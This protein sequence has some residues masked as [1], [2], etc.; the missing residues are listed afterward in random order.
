MAFPLGL[1][2]PCFTALVPAPTKHFFDARGDHAKSVCVDA[3]MAAGF[4]AE[5][6]FAKTNNT[7][8]GVT[9]IDFKV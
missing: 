6:G 9:R 4:T 1:T 3:K 7:S 5:T 2:Y 8:A